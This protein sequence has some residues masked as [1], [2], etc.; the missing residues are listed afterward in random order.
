MEVV[1]VSMNSSGFCFWALL[2]FLPAFSVGHSHSGPSHPS[3]HS[4]C[5]DEAEAAAEK[6]ASDAFDAVA[7]RGGVAFGRINNAEGEKQNFA[8]HVSYGG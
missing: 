5:L 1:V 6:A 8:T 4:H 7:A 2:L 3:H